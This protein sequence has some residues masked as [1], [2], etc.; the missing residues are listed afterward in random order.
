MVIDLT[1]EGCDTIDGGQRLLHFWQGC[2]LS[3]SVEEVH[4]HDNRA[5]MYYY[6]CCFVRDEHHWLR[7]GGYATRD[8]DGRSLCDPTLRCD[9]CG[10][11]MTDTQDG[12]S[13]WSD[14]ALAA[15]TTTP[16]SFTHKA[17]CDAFEQ[18]RGGGQAWAAMGL[19]C[20]LYFL[21]K[22]LNMSWRQVQAS[23]RRMMRGGRVGHRARAGW[24]GAA[25][26]DVLAAA[27]ALLAHVPVQW[28]WRHASPPWQ[29]R[30]RTM[31]HKRSIPPT[32]RGR[33]VRPGPPLPPWSVLLQQALWARKAGAWQEVGRLLPLLATAPDVPP[34]DPPSRLVQA[35]CQLQAD[36]WEHQA[37]A[38]HARA[39]TAEEAAVP[40][41]LVAAVAREALQTLVRRVVDALDAPGAPN[42]SVPEVCR[43]L[44]KDI[45]AV[46][47]DALIDEAERA[48]AA[49]RGDVDETDTLGDAP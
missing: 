4:D 16:M 15:D 2:T 23:A 7:G 5:S 36:Y 31:P 6:G 37:Q 34:P 47:W 43:E 32:R 14:A 45:E 21:A 12:N 48:R 46:P 49:R 3:I 33:S 40:I 38:W 8:A 29:R 9:H 30:P 1:E 25:V 20:L 22:N 17:C 19:E 11:V 13:Q 10:A 26:C 35:W 42:P 24:S 18:A 41:A 27:G 44:L 39:R 28:P